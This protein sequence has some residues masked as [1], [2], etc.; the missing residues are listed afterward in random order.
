MRIA[1]LGWGSLLWDDETERGREFNRH[2]EGGTWC[3]HGPSL[4]LEFSRISASRS[5]ALTLVLDYERGVTCRVHYALSNRK[6]WRDAVCDLRCREGTI[7]KRI[8]CYLPWKRE[9]KQWRNALFEARAGIKEWA[10]DREI[11]A[12]VWTALSC[13]F[14][15]EKSR[16]VWIKAAKSHLQ[17]LD[18]KGKSKAAEYIFRAPRSVDT[19]L[20]RAMQSEPW[21]RTL[22][23][24]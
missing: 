19:P 9:E 14:K 4:K 6:C 8:G 22:T 11:H 13:N 7:L 23:D 17:R 24:G 12:V 10:R 18:P 1:I 21:F 15:E 20:G 3:H 2:I 5:R 16:P